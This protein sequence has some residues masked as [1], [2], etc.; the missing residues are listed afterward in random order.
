MTVVFVQL[1]VI[2]LG[3]GLGHLDDLGE[4]IRHTIVSAVFESPLVFE[5]LKYRLSSPYL[6]PQILRDECS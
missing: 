3:F 1:S 2:R 6:H 5:N 4:G